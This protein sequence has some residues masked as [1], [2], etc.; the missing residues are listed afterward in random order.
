MT[1]TDIVRSFWRD[2]CYLA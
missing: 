1:F 2:A